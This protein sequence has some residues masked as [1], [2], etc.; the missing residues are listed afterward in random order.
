MAPFL[1]P[2]RPRRSWFFALC[3]ASVGALA[4]VQACS[5]S[6][7]TGG[8]KSAKNGDARPVKV[9]HEPCDTES[10]SARKTD[11]NKDG[12][13]EIVTVMNGDRMVCQA[14]D[15]NFDGKVD[16]F[17]YYDDAGQ[18]RRVESDYDRDGRIDEII[19]YENGVISR[20]D[21]EM[22]LD[23][24][25]DTWVL[26]ANG[27]PVGQERDSDGD[28][29][30]DQWWKFPDPQHLEC[31]LVSK[32]VDGDGQPDANSEID[33]CKPAEDFSAPPPGASGSAAGGLNGAPPPPP[34]PPPPTPPPPPPPA[35]A[36]ASPASRAPASPLSPDRP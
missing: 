27:V 1:S 19:Y 21:R 31:A 14:L 36:S 4:S 16:R 9:V 33:T 35:G 22:N 8:P 5:Q 7:S 24:K 6:L 15:L 18:V 34:P 3:L 25:L 30:V 32:D 17:V 11:A 12:K 13:F 26:Y 2:L 20:K 23:G 29:R 10:S 28:G